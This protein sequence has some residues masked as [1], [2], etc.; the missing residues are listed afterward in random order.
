[1]LTIA[2]IQI[3][4]IRKNIKHIHLYVKPPDGRVLVTAPYAMTDATLERFIK[5]KAAWL[6]AHVATYAARPRPAPHAYQTGETLFVWGRPCRLQ[7]HH[8]ARAAVVLHGDLLVLTCRPD[9]DADRREKI[10]R[11][12]YREQ[13]KAAVALRL[14][15]WEA[16]TGLKAAGFQTK[17]MTTRWGTCNVKTR[18]LWFSLQL[19]QRPPEC[20]EYVV[21][22]EVLH[23]KERNHN[24]RFYGLLDQYMPGWRERK[25]ALS[26][27]MRL[28]DD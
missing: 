16:A 8:A 19:A 4:V 1:M 5:T 3:E 26:M 2:G 28:Q 23:L 25:K 21:L 18:K 12:W 20:L 10:V 17:A 7:V 6:T 13:L 14:P 15:V 22:H 27:G 11:E 24:A 9:A